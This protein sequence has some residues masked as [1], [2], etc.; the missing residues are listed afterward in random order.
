MELYLMRHG[1]AEEPRAGQPDAGR[2]LTLEGREKAAAV[3]RLAQQGGMDPGLVLTS[4]YLRALQTAEVAAEVLEHRGETVVVPSLVPHG[5][6]EEVW[7]E[8]R[9]FPEAGSILLTSHEPLLG[10]LMGFLLN[11]PALRVEVRKASIMRIDVLGLRGV[12]RGEL[13][14]LITPRISLA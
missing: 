14:W 4:P 9:L 1:I 2:R 3:V 12:P 7:E 5:S 8:I 10:A 6:P 13:Q 11:S